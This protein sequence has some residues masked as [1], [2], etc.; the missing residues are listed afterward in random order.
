MDAPPRCKRSSSAP[1]IHGDINR[2]LK[3]AS[4]S[5]VRGHGDPGVPRCCAV[6]AGPMDGRWAIKKAQTECTS[7]LCYAQETREP[8]TTPAALVM[9]H[10]TL[11]GGWGLW[12]KT[13]NRSFDFNVC[14]YI[15][16]HIL[17]NINIIS[18][19]TPAARGSQSAP[20]GAA[21]P[22]ACWLKAFSWAVTTPKSSVS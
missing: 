14:V 17:S 10:A 1:H 12:E 5:V 4:V 19:S 20:G 3:H 21:N 2:G 6:C 9:R 18:I 7:L 15:C 11:A 8:A 13:E 16:A 22:A